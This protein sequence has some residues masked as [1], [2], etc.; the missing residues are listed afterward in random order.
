M[1][2]WLAAPALILALALALAAGGSPA[3]AAPPGHAPQPPEAPKAAAPQAQ[4]PQAEAPQA[5]A[6]TDQIA[7]QLAKL[8]QQVQA[9]RAEFL[10]LAA[11]SALASRDLLRRARAL[12]AKVAKL[13]SQAAALDARVAAL[14][15]GVRF[16]PNLAWLNPDSLAE[17]MAR[18]MTNYQQLLERLG[19]T[20]STAMAPPGQVGVSWKEHFKVTSLP[21]VATRTFVRA[22]VP[23][24]EVQRVHVDHRYGDVRV[25]PSPDDSVRLTVQVTVQGSMDEAEGQRLADQVALDIQLDTA[26]T[27]QA[28]IPEIHGQ[29]D[30]SIRVD[31]VMQ[32]PRTLGACVRNSYGD[33]MLSSL[34]SRAE[35]NATYGDVLGYDL[36]ADARLEAHNG[37]IKVEH[38]AGALDVADQSGVV[39][40]R[41]AEG[42]VS[43][44]GMGSEMNLEDL[45][46]GAHLSARNGSLRLRNAVGPLDLVVQNATV[47]VESVRG[48][49]TLNSQLGRVELAQVAGPV[50]A[51]CVDGSL[52]TSFVEGLQ[53]L[54]TRRCQLRVENPGGDVRMSGESAPLLLRLAEGGAGHH[55]EATNRLGTVSLE[56]P[57]TGSATIHAATSFGTIYSDLPIQRRD[58]GDWQRGEAKL[59]AGEAQISLQAAFSSIRITTM[60]H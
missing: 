24:P 18:A 55:Y 15:Q 32:V 36:G 34:A 59:G 25:L 1:K 6:L 41:R 27:A 58:T 40:L 4:A 2:R 23:P 37:D 48:P 43:V 33:V 46:A 26:C 54:Q 31:V 16:I 10:F 3:A 49:V 39:V 20:S 8:G 28:S 17:A 45:R 50:T 11:D 13:A 47:G 29:A 53:D 22:L 42:P 7:T 51:Q 52:G 56:L 19:S 30:R 9:V 35:A 21:T 57:P 14:P 38:A 12:E 60:G 5:P 44:D